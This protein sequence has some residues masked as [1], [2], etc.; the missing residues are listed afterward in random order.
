[1]YTYMYF[2]CA[3]LYMCVYMYIQESVTFDPFMSMSVPIPGKLRN[4]PVF[5]VPSN[6]KH[7]PTKVHVHVQ[8][9]TYRYQCISYTILHIL[10][11]DHAVHS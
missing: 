5:F 2:L 9:Y 10:L 8:C 4:L 11:F 7:L 1:M 6:P 3:L